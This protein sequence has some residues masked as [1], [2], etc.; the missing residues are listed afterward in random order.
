MILRVQEA[1][2]DTSGYNPAV[3][4]K[5]LDNYRSHPTILDVYSN[6]SYGGELIPCIPDNGVPE[7][8]PNVLHSAYP[9]LVVGVCNGVMT[10][11]GVNPSP[12]NV[13]EINHVSL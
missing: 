8:V 5:L 6:L 9:L 4:T 11:D 7:W 12:Y 1:F 2:P 10:K 13:R 3:V